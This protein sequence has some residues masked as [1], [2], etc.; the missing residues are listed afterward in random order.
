MSKGDRRERKGGPKICE[1]QFFERS[2]L[3]SSPVFFLQV[4]CGIY[5]YIYSIATVAGYFGV[6]SYTYNLDRDYG[7]LLLYPVFFSPFF[8]SETRRGAW[9]ERKQ[10]TRWRRGG[11]EKKIVDIPFGKVFAIFIF[12]YYHPPIHLRRC[13]LSFC[14]SFIFIGIRRASRRER[15]WTTTS[16]PPL[17]PSTGPRYHKVG[18]IVGRF[19]FFPLPSSSQRDTDYR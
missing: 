13:V 1:I 5:I 18:K 15:G 2:S 17:P 10:R 9:H 8:I 14:L 16:I 19:S 11:M 3:T 4:S 12:I 7:F 6:R